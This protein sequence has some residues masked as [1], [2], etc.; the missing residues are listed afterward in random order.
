MKLYNRE[1]EEVENEDREKRIQ[2]IAEKNIAFLVS[3]YGI[4]EIFLREKL[5][6]LAVVEKSGKSY[7]A[8]Y[9][10]KKTEYS[11]HAS[12]ASFCGF[13]KQENF[14]DIWNF[15]VA[16]YTSDNN[17]DNT[18][19]HEL[20][21]YFS[22]NAEMPFN[23]NEVGYVKSGVSI[24]GY[25]RNDE[26]VD[27][28]LN[29]DGLNEG[30][31]EYLTT[32]NYGSNCPDVYFY[33]SYIAGIL[34]NSQNNNLINAYFSKDYNDFK[35][36]LNDFDRRQN[37]V[38]SNQLISLKTTG[39]LVDTKLLKACLNYSLS[40]CND[41]EQ[42]KTERKRLLPLF[43]S[44]YENLNLAY[45]QNDFNLQEFFVN[46]FNEK[47]AIVKQSSEQNVIKKTVVQKEK[48]VLDSAEEAIEESTR[49]GKV[50]EQAQTMKKRQQERTN[51]DI[52]KDNNDLG[53]DDE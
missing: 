12:A 2:A 18:I 32:Q 29:A 49:T 53:L 33:Q 19:S 10:G 16:V 9:N 25:N 20:F 15:D 52:E 23:E 31:T 6:K 39:T 41:M 47:K 1:L 17:N 30:I 27:N 11:N 48:S 38:S 5:G 8:E 22:Q 45:D 46:T 40:F 26:L 14:G 50:N 37:L 28:A 24:S 51:P 21:H 13:M 43:K 3:R 35:N 42:L 4:D 34:L 44:M 7:L 36:F